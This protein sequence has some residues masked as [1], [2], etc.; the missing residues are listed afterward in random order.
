VFANTGV[1]Q[2][3]LSGGKCI[4]AL[5][6]SIDCCTLVDVNL[7]L[8]EVPSQFHPSADHQARVVVATSP[9]ANHVLAF[10]QHHG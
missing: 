2:V 4:E 3:P 10:K 9:N 7:D 8:L 5:D 6:R 1:Q